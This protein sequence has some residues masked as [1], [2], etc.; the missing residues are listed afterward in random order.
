MRLR[1]FSVLTFDCY[2]TLI[3]WESGIWRALQPLVARAP[4]PPSRDAALA[5]FGAAESAQERETPSLIYSAL[6]ARVH[7]RLAAT[8]G[9]ASDAAEATAFG[10]SV[11]D[12][13]AF[14][15]SSAALAYLKRHYKL[16]ILSNV[17]RA[18]FAAS[19]AKLGI[20]FDA[21]YTAEDIG[22]Y[23]PDPANFRYLLDRLGAQGIRP[24][25]ILHVAQ[26]LYHDHAPAN[27]AGLAS[28]W[29]DRRQ[30]AGGGAT[31]PADAAVRYDF[32][33]SSLAAL[34]A[35]HEAEG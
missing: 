19:N 17:H 3:D 25:D 20:D 21:V 8:W 5:A 31:P 30:G 11:P 26:S 14:A 4:N 9:V 12:W 13:P 29:I 7:E 10:N 24:G 23:K 27:R 35:A 34:A 1:D 22:S 6:L 33:F 16:V 15:D 28:A 18:G 2:G 32:R